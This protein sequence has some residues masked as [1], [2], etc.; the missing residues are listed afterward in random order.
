MKEIIEVERAPEVFRDHFDECLKHFGKQLNSVSNKVRLKTIKSFADF[1]GV[2][3]PT[4]KRWFDES[5][6]PPNGEARI[7]SMCYLDA[8]GYRVI[9]FERMPKVLRS[10]AELIGFG[11]VSAREASDLIENKKLSRMY[12]LFRGA[13]LTDEKRDRMWNVWKE[14]RH[15]LEQKKKDMNGSQSVPR[16]SKAGGLFGVLGGLVV[17][18]EGLSENEL[19]ELLDPQF[20]QIVSRLNGV[21]SKTFEMEKKPVSTNQTEI[22]KGADNES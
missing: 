15:A 17:L 13:T 3:Q 9:E 19:K 10:F 22:A 12:E 18:L 11:I 7:K 1:C 4:V 16:I 6:S 8:C 14:R 2:A 5:W 21:C 20:L